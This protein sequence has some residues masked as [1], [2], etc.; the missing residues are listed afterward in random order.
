MKVKK[1]VSIY[2]RNCKIHPSGYY[3]IYQYF[4]EMDSVPMKYRELVPDSV[5]RNYFFNYNL[6]NKFIY[7]IVI[8]FKSIF[9]LLCDVFIYK[10]D[11]VIINREICPKFQ[12]KIHY[13]LEKKLL[14]KAYV[15]WDI[16]D[17]ILLN[18]EISKSEWELLENESNK[19]SL[20]SEYLK[21]MLSEDNW[22]KV[23]YIP[24]T[25][26]DY[27][28]KEFRKPD[29]R[30]EVYEKEIRI[31]WL[32]TVTNIPYLEKCI[33]YLEK[34]AQVLEEQYNKR[35][36]LTCVCNKEV[37]VQTK[38]LVL[39][40]VTWEREKALD[41][42]HESHIG[43]MPLEDNEFTRGKG[44]FKLIQYMSA[45]IPVVA[46]NVGF[47]KE[48]VKDHFGFLV[49]GEEEWSHAIIKLATDYKYWESC[50]QNAKK[51]W[52]QKYSYDQ[53]KTYWSNNVK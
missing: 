2:L 43:I 49:T 14:K 12:T 17:A 31:I 52:D 28:K 36:V 32:A 20:L 8:V 24:T 50:S 34:V 6:L 33:P 45:S 11:I 51:E 26:G 35:L 9:D 18:G 47:N 22:S 19:I 44:G 15:I 27:I 5:Y 21:N 13:L 23:D 7:S 46:S 30:K 39:R 29:M 1:K 3:R 41:I 53:I 25:D 38:Y 10:P 48:V 40:N 42:M 16:D 4:R 37:N